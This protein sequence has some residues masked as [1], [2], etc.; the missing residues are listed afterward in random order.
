V[1]PAQRL[2]GFLQRDRHGISK[3]F[4]K[5]AAIFFRSSLAHGGANFWQ[6][7]T[8]IFKRLNAREIL[9]LPR[10]IVAI[11]G[12]RIGKSGCNSPISS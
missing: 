8:Q 6:S 5:L 3:V 10:Q 11:P 2:F 1:N 7:H 12:T 4:Q 9:Q